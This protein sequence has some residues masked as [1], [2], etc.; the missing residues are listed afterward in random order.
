MKTDED[1]HPIFFE[2]TGEFHHWLEANHGSM[3]VVWV[4]YYKKATGRASMSW[5]ESVDIALCFGWIDGIRKSIDDQ[6]YKIRFTPRRPGSTWSPTNVQK[7]KELIEAGMMAEMGLKAFNVRKIRKDHP[8]VHGAKKAWALDVKY[9]E[10]LEK[11]PIA[12]AFFNNLAPSFKKVTIR[13]VMSAKRE[14]TRLR[15]LNKLIE[16]ARKGKKIPPLQSN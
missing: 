2:G 11:E 7:A 5:T 4:G 15:R 12:L 8:A 16:E 3:D 10:I 1:Q 6:R 9:Q 13:W 14:E